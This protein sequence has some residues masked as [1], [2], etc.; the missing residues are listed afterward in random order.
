MGSHSS[1]H[2]QRRR[3]PGRAGRWAP[4]F[5]RVAGS[6]LG[7]NSPE[8]GP[9]TPAWPVRVPVMRWL[10]PALRAP[11]RPGSPA[12]N[13]NAGQDAPGSTR[14]CTHRAA[15]ASRKATGCR[16]RPPEEGPRAPPP[17]PP[18]WRWTRRKRWAGLGRR[19]GRTPWLCGPR[20]HPALPRVSSP[21]RLSANRQRGPSPPGEPGR[22][23][24]P[25]CSHFRGAPSPRRHFLPCR[26]IRGAGT[27]TDFEGAG[28]AHSHKGL[29]RR[30]SQPGGHSRRQGTRCEA[31]S[32]PGNFQAALLTPSGLRA[33]G[34]WPGD[35]ASCPPSCLLLGGTKDGIYL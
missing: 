27:R 15:G 21:G 20:S 35:T 33:A 19:A 16:Q 34:W 25:R 32:G 5:A 26:S 10:W 18:T 23:R 3:G 28:R 12:A 31:S 2:T 6:A 14:V 8:P 1:H 11:A 29:S 7:A 9:A 17:P 22:R 4:G 13:G 30:L 24:P